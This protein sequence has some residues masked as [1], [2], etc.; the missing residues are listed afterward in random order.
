MTRTHGHPPSIRVAK[1]ACILVLVE[2]RHVSC[3]FRCPVHR[4][5]RII[6]QRE[7]AIAVRKTTYGVWTLPP[8]VQSSSSLLLVVG[9]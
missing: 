5:A 9:F 2:R 4:V 3:E 1:E 7:V 8:Y 6:V